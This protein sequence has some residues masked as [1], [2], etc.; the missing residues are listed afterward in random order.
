MGGG[1]VQMVGIEADVVMLDEVARKQVDETNEEL[2]GAF[3]RLGVADG[4]Y[5]DVAQVEHEERVEC[6]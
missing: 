6:A 5:H 4:E 2:G 1:D 3:A